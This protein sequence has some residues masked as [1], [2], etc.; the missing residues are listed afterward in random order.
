MPINLYTLI[1]VAFLLLALFLPA[2]KPEDTTAAQERH[3]AAMKGWGEYEPVEV[4]NPFEL[5]PE[6][7]ARFK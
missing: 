6:E 1:G 5:T 7:K 2:C 3:R 4:K